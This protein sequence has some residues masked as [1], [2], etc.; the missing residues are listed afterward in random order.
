M[1]DP[2]G[3]PADLERDVVLRDGTRVLIRPIRPEDA[4]RLV[5]LYGRLST[6]SAYQRFFTVMRRLPPD[7]VKFLANVDYRR[8]LAL[9]AVLE[10]DGVPAVIGVG[11]YEPYPDGAVELAF[12]VEDRWQNQG[13]GTVLLQDLL[14]AAAARGIDRFRAY[15]L[16]DNRRMLDMLNR[17]TDVKERRRDGSVIE[18]SFAR[19][20]PSG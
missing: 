20:A 9:V 15:V 2:P 14:A 16:A 12:V 10:A 4:D 6:H 19:R 11:R 3:Y 8:R 13:L 5:A 1:A 17:F 18:L 7:W